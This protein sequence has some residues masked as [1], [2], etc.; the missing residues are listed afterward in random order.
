MLPF[1][2]TWGCD[3]EQNTVSA[4]YLIIG[5]VQELHSH[6]IARILKSPEKTMDII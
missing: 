2:S 1:I 5:A 6:N 4:D 3:V